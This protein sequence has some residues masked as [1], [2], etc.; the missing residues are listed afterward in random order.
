MQRPLLGGSDRNVADAQGA[1]RAG[2]GQALL[3]RAANP[4]HHQLDDSNVHG[5]TVKKYSLI[6]TQCGRLGGAIYAEA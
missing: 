5:W 2:V 4:G 3:A 6:F 1:D